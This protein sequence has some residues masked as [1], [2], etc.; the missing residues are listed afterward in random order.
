[1]VPL[2]DKVIEVANETLRNGLAEVPKGSNDGHE[3]RAFL[4]G[5]A[6][7]PGEYWC[8]YFAIACVHKAFERAGVH[9]DKYWIGKVRHGGCDL[10]AQQARAMKPCEIGP[11]FSTGA[12]YL[13]WKDDPSKPGGKDF[14]HAGIA[15]HLGTD[16]SGEFTG[17]EGN[18]NLDGSRNGYGVF[19]HTRH[20]RNA[21]FVHW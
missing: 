5:T 17:I 12:I 3:L 9:L 8:L 6:F 11:N 16:G 15:T 14:Y 4:G 13:L 21:M 20:L 1:M 2:G 10:L 7:S 19:Q 18:T